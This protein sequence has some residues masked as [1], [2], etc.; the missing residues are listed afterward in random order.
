[1]AKDVFHQ[2]VKNALIKEGW[3][4]THDPLTIRISEAVK[5]QIDLAAETTI[6]AERDSE[7][8]AVEIKSFIGDS[9]ISSFH[10]A[11][12][13]YLNYSQAL[14]EQEPNRIVYLAIPFETYYD[15]FQLPFIQRML[16]RYQ[17][18]LMIYD[19]KQEEVRQWI[20]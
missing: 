1:M 13:Q 9:D 16:Q 14:E 5:L 3:N 2:Q 11:L 20:K 8:I 17:V 7:K 12:G 10:T 18:K 4:I 19:P 15:F 6:A